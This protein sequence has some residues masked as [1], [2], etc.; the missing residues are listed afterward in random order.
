MAVSGQMRISW[1]SQLITTFVTLRAGVSIT[2]TNFVHSC[3]WISPQEGDVLLTDSL[4][5]SFYLPPALHL[6][7]QQ[8]SIVCL[9]LDGP[10]GKTTCDRA[11]SSLAPPNSAGTHLSLLHGISSGPHTLTV[12]IVQSEFLRNIDQERCGLVRFETVRQGSLDPPGCP[13][14]RAA[15]QRTRRV[16]RIGEDRQDWEGK[17]KTS[18]GDGLVGSGAGDPRRVFDSFSFFNE[19]DTLLV[20]LEELDPVVEAF[21]LVEATHTHSGRPKPLYYHEE[22][23]QL[24]NKFERFISKIEHVI[25]VPPASAD[26]ITREAAQ[27]DALIE[28]LHH[29]GA[30]ARDLVVIADVDEIPSRS[31]LETLQDCG[32]PFPALLQQAWFTY[33]FDWK[34]DIAWGLPGLEGVVVVEGAMLLGCATGDPLGCNH[35]TNA[36]TV[37]PSLLRRM[38]REENYPVTLAAAAAAA[39][40]VT[41]EQEQDGSCNPLHVTVVGDAGWHMSSFGGI[42]RVRE[43]LRSCIPLQFGTDFYTD[44]ARLERLLMSGVA[45]W[46]M[47]GIDSKE[48]GVFERW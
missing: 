3:K 36:H 24:P 31:T 16:P 22:L 8:R 30:R 32:G 19:M 25:Y 47:L 45:T 37:T 18:G 6:E 43:R 26:E 39:S 48:E 7:T 17:V 23:Q 38:F 33:F 46:E 20:R 28:G 10:R 9:Q 34:A 41:T 13:L 5:V 14:V 29:R 11:D 1:L 27:R 42:E 2:P 15:L 4:L 12:S 40:E 21:I 35:G 44:P